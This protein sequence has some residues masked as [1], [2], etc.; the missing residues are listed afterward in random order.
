M[1]LSEIIYY[2]GF[3]FIAA[4]VLTLNVMWWRV[5]I[6]LIIESLPI[7]KNKK[8]ITNKLKTVTR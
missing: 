7:F 5:M 4:L 6:N 2:T 8:R 3:C 1:N